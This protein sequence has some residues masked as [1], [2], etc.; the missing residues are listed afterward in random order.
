MQIICCPCINKKYKHYSWCYKL[1]FDFV[2]K[3]TL[4]IL[5]LSNS[6][7]QFHAGIIT[8]QVR[9]AAIEIEIQCGNLNNWSICKLYTEI[10]FN[11]MQNLERTNLIS[12]INN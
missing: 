4:H 9:F 2:M 6:F 5:W 8:V 1:K 10:Y 11:D 3:V 12:I 7:K